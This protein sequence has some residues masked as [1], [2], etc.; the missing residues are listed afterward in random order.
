MTAGGTTSSLSG[1]GPSATSRSTGGTQARACSGRTGGALAALATSPR[2]PGLD[3]FTRLVFH[4]FLPL[5]FIE[6]AAASAS[7]CSS[8][9]GF[10]EAKLRQSSVAALCL[11]RFLT[12]RGCRHV[13]LS[14]QSGYCV[15]F[16]EGEM[17]ARKREFLSV[18]VV[19]RPNSCDISRLRNS[20]LSILSIVPRHPHAVMKQLQYPHDDSGFY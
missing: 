13:M 18:H 2:S 17:E 9:S 7:G 15:Y 14:Q 5:G 10:S 8:E 16:R 12:V 4:L 19:G 20:K 3:T 6:A 11:V 1:S